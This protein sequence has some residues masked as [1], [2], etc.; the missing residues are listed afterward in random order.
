MAVSAN[1]RLRQLREEIQRH[2]HSYY[3]LN[4]PT[5]SDH[6]YDALMKELI[7]LEAKHPDL[8]AP[9]SP[10]HRVAG[11]PIDG[12]SSVEHAIPMMSIDN[13]YDTAEVRAFDARVR[14]GLDGDTPR[15]G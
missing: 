12:F 7:D 14:K 10:T 1:N 2:D 8:A 5:I 6:D 4:K 11:S 15:Y 13:T 9:D 3:V